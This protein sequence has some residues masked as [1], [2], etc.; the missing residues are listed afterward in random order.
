MTVT[1]FWS[2]EQ[3]I[4]AIWSYPVGLE[5]KI[6]AS[7]SFTGL[8]AAR[9]SRYMSLQPTG[10]PSDHTASGRHLYSTTCGFCEVTV[11]DCM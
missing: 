4:F 6:W 7:P 10:A 11:T 3:S 5:S 9:Y 2:A 1:V 8:T